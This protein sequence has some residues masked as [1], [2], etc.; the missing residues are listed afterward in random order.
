MD[1]DYFPRFDPVVIFSTHNLTILLSFPW[2]QVASRSELN[3]FSGVQV[4]VLGQLSNEIVSIWCFDGFEDMIEILA[5]QV[6][7]LGDSV[8][9]VLNN[10][11]KP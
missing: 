3:Q 4:E 6:F 8:F 10:V 9:V 1:F 11:R 5:N 2:T 7:K